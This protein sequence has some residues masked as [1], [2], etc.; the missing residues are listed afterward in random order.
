MENAMRSGLKLLTVGLVLVTAA[1]AGC[2]STTA[3]SDGAIQDDVQIA[4]TAS[5][6]ASTADSPP[7]TNQDPGKYVA[8]APPVYA[9][10]QSCTTPIADNAWTSPPLGPNGNTSVSYTDSIEVTAGSN[11]TNFVWISTTVSPSGGGGLVAFESG[12]ESN[13]MNN[14]KIPSTKNNNQEVI[15][16]SGDVG[17]TVFQIQDSTGTLGGTY[18]VNVV[19]Q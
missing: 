7:G 11:C 9:P 17:T 6:G 15:Y 4:P 19:A 1:V 5:A 13:P 10:S 3:G 18:T 8:P 14:M 12:G 16:Y 2:S